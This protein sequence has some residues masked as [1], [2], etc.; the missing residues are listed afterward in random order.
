MVLKS[1]FYFGNQPE[2]GDLV[3][4]DSKVNNK[5]SF[6]DKL[7]ESPLIAIFSDDEKKNDI[8]IKRVIGE[9]GDTLEYK[10]GHVYRNGKLLNENY[11]KEQ[12]FAPFEK[13][14]VP[15][16][17]VFVMGDNR[18]N[19]NDSREIG[20]VPIDNVIGKVFIRFYPFD[21]FDFINK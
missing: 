16:N 12:L 7:T 13:V 6:L 3:I 8:W 4:I 11:I 17:H 18:N 1:A 5:R 20:P 9:Q 10:N 14:V 2:Y 15:E 19:S 21:K